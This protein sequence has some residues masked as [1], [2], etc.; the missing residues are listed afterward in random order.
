M[1]FEVADVHNSPRTT[2]PFV[3]GP[4]F[5]A[6]RYELRY[7]TMLDLIRTAYNVDP[8]KIFGGPSWLE[9]DRFDVFAKIPASSSVESRR[10]ML[11]ALLADRFQLVTHND[12][13]PMAAYTLV[14][15]KQH[16]LKEADGSK[17][18]KCEFNVQNAPSGPPAGGGPIQLPTFLYSCR[19]TS[20]EQ[21]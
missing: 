18:T 21:F 16:Q 17:E 4:F 1:K 10:F 19:N 20:M 3:R 6:G 9:M 13:K 7:A 14:V 2:Q 5:G 8:E 15:G 11:Q 12:T